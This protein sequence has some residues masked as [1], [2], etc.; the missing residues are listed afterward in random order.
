MPQRQQ[1]APGHQPQLHKEPRE[2]ACIVDLSLS[3]DLKRQVYFW[4]DD[5]LGAKELSLDF[6]DLHGDLRLIR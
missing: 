5:D 6:Y 1:V 2:F 4:G 3:L